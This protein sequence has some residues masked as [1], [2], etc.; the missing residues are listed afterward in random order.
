M[1]CFKCGFEFSPQAGACPRCKERDTPT[2]T[3]RLPDL[4]SSETQN[5]VHILPC[6]NCG[7][8]LF[9]SSRTCPACGK[10]ISQS[11]PGFA[12]RK[13]SADPKQTATNIFLLLS[14]VVLAILLYYLLKKY[15]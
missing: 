4:Q 10:L 14:G 15:L 7:F 3:R 9:P 1:Q 13:V 6:P 2:G 8:I 11:A 12:P 5:L